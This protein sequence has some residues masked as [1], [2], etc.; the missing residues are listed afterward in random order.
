MM[1]GG[2][3]MNAKIV[4][5]SLLVIGLVMIGNSSGYS[6]ALGSPK[7][8]GKPPV[9][10][11]FYA[12]DRVTFG[13]PLRIYIAAEDPDGDMLR[14]AVSVSQHG[15]GG[16]T[17]DWTYLRAGNEEGFKGYLQWNMMSSYANILWDRTRVTVKVS[18]FDKRGNESDEVVMPLMLGPFAVS[19]PPPPTP[20]DQKDIQKLGHVMINL[21]NPYRDTDRHRRA[22]L[23]LFPQ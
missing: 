4:M 22:G 10:T 18:V 3:E 7:L 17:T 13:D 2:A 20:F 1:E 9:I 11:D 19:Y 8:G 16:Y 5:I 6:Q 15:Y 21:H 23:F 12:V 14:I